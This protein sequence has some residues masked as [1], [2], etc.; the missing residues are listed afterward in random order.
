MRRFE[1]EAELL[2]RLQHP[3]IAQIHEADTDDAGRG[4]QPFFAMEYVDGVPLTTFAESRKL[5]RHQRL[6]LFLKICDAMQYAHEHG[7]VHRDLKP[8]NVLVTAR[9]EPK[10]LDFG[11]ACTRDVDVRS[12]SVHTSSGQILGTIPYMSPEQISGNPERI[13]L[14]S[15]VYSLGVVLY[16]LLTGRLP[17]DVVGKPIHEAAR[18]IVEDEP[19]HPRRRQRELGGDLGTVLI[20]SLEKAPERRYASV[21]DFA[22]DVRNVLEMR[23]VN[24]RPPSRID[25]LAKFGRRNRSALAIAAI[26]T[27]AL[28]A[29][30]AVAMRDT[31]PTVEDRIA[32][33]LQGLRAT[34][35]AEPDLAARSAAIHEL[36]S[37]ATL[38]LP[39][40][41]Y[42]VAVTELS[43]YIRENLPLRKRSGAPEVRIDRTVFHIE[44]I[45]MA[46]RALKVL[47]DRSGLQPEF[48]N[49]DF[50]N[51]NL[52]DLDLSGLNFSHC[53]LDGSFL[54]SSRWRNSAFQHASMRGIAA[55][56]ADFTGADFFRAD[57]RDAKLASDDLT[58][59]NL[60]QADDLGFAL[61]A[62]VTG[63]SPER[64]AR[65]GC[66]LAP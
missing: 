61:C 57:L 41:A 13:D 53:V 43:L 58:D 48:L 47:Y 17:L 7:V 19:V 37:L 40:N 14:R 4:P 32:A 66:Q 55:W 31:T 16:E 65:L 50:S 20:K 27:A 2:G 62:D 21:A 26:A 12:A 44:D 45:R 52:G 3:G 8:S 15:D 42:Q 1:R 63:I 54:S 6:E 24:A 10:I 56:N 60:E 9:G 34:K 51:L 33:A 46:L 23:P 5:T 18:S 64:A 49:A 35:G 30:L 11:V 25:R 59:T 22:A 28:I 38:D 39:E 29:V 36:E